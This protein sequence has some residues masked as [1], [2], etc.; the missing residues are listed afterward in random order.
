LHDN[1]LVD[2]VRF[3][4]ALTKAKT[5]PTFQVYVFKGFYVVRL[6]ST[7]RILKNVYPEDTVKGGVCDKSIQLVSIEPATA[8]TGLCCGSYA[9][10]IGRGNHRW[11][12]GSFRKC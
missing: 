10:D 12:S 1:L 9:A 4:N 11:S 6:K 5:V 3:T 7:E 8:A 2:S